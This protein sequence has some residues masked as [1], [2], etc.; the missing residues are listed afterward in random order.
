MI[1]LYLYTALT[2]FSISGYNCLDQSILNELSQ[3]DTEDYL[4]S[5][6]NKDCSK[7]NEGTLTIKGY[8][9][10]FSDFIRSNGKLY[11]LCTGK[12]IQILNV[13]VLNSVF[14]D[15]DIDASGDELQLTVIAPA[16][17]VYGKRNINLNGFVGKAHDPA[18]AKPG[19]KGDK[20]GQPG[21]P[22]GPGGSFL[23]IGNS[24]F[25]GNNLTIS[26]NG[27]NGG[28]GQNGANGID[29]VLRSSLK[30][31]WVLK[32]F[33]SPTLC[34]YERSKI[35]LN[36]N[37]SQ[38]FLVDNN[39]QKSWFECRKVTLRDSHY[40][41]VT[42]TIKQ[43][44]TKD[45]IERG[46]GGNGG[47]GGIGGRPGNV[48]TVELSSFSLISHFTQ[49]GRKGDDG[50]GGAGGNPAG[51][52]DVVTVTQ[53]QLFYHVNTKITD[54]KIKIGYANQPIN[55]LKGINSAGI[56][57]PTQPKAFPKSFKIHY[58]A[59]ALIQFKTYLR[60]SSSDPE[61]TKSLLQFHN[62]IDR[63]VHV[64]RM[65]N[66]P[67]FLAEFDSIENHFHTLNNNVDFT[68]FYVS[69]L[70]R[71]PVYVDHGN[72]IIQDRK[73]LAYG[74]SAILGRLY[75]LQELEESVLVTDVET[76][77]QLTRNKLDEVKYWKN[78]GFMV[79]KMVNIDRLKGEYNNRVNS[80]IEEA[81]SLVQ[82]NIMP[83]IINIE[84]QFH[85]NLDYLIN[86]TQKHIITALEEE[87]QVNMLINEATQK[88]FIK[89]GCNFMIVAGNILLLF[90][91]IYTGIAGISLL[92]V[93]TLGKM[94][95]KDTNVPNITKLPPAVENLNDTL[96]S[97]Q[98]LRK[99]RLSKFLEN[100]LQMANKYPESLN[101][102]SREL[103]QLSKALAQSTS[104]SEIQAVEKEMRIVVK[105]KYD[106][107]N[108]DGHSDFISAVALRQGRLRTKLKVPKFGRGPNR[109]SKKRRKKTDKSQE[110][111]DASTVLETIMNML[112]LGLA[113]LDTFKDLMDDM[114]KLD[115]LNDLL[116]KVKGKIKKLY[117]Y[118]SAVYDVLFPLLDD[119]S[120]AI[121]NLSQN[122]QN[123]SQIALIVAKYDMKQL[124]QCITDFITNFTEEFKA[125]AMF[126]NTLNNVQGTFD[127]LFSVFNQIQE[128]VREINFA[129]QMAD[130]VSEGVTSIA[131]TDT[132][133]VKSINKL[134]TTISSNIVLMYYKPAISAFKQFVFPFAHDYF[135][136]LILPKNLDLISNLTDL[137]ISVDL[138][139]HHLS[140]KLQYYKS[141]LKT[142]HSGGV[143]RTKF[144]SFRLSTK[145]FFIWKNEQH[146][147]MISQ[148]LSGQE[149]VAYADI[150]ES[151]PSKDAVKFSEVGIYLKTKNQ[152]AQ[153]ELNKYL[154][155]L[156]ITMLHYGNSYY[157]YNHTF[158]LIT[159]SSVRISYSFDNENGEPID[160]SDTYDKIKQGTYMLSPYALW[161][162]KI[163]YIHEQLSFDKLK[164]Y[165]NEVD[166]ELV[167]KGSYID[168]T[169]LRGTDLKEDMYYKPLNAYK[170]LENKSL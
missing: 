50:N 28:R 86:E 71:I 61:R 164:V 134:A 89:L 20:H 130:L 74:Y 64:R 48:L 118:L 90:R 32:F 148:L 97:F 70:E 158:Y 132:E 42:Y 108:E 88:L 168:S 162:F 76:Y 166:V 124:L 93:G 30:Y 125:Q 114:E 131:I 75:F 143:H 139:I 136:E 106:E 135:K 91:N 92:I 77:L 58:F 94:V 49:S 110:E 146:R 45:D 10:K 154:E 87:Q 12:K 9:V 44:I 38:V 83:Q 160:R 96:Q 17:K 113:I 126:I 4:N 41:N 14:I 1:T 43:F 129:N 85:D 101:G 24:F 72:P 56:K 121:S 138:Q 157:R 133:Y 79:Q 22:G 116:S 53:T 105:R 29:L 35:F 170:A 31:N 15:M 62:L 47:S 68:P 147:K 6:L 123:L 57:N 95:V 46:T 99:D 103:V 122:L 8:N 67:G 69:L 3:S 140:N 127:V 161:K 7:S 104:F 59:V 155:T 163:S 26:A 141:I 73:V 120:R 112:D 34:E 40:T 165:E 111:Y 84:K 55:G 128:Y 159:S 137:I 51:L 117:Q 82:T 2:C 78:I 19:G 102:L 150:K 100:A 33:N 153:T 151:V 60:E 65:F 37:F 81:Q 11:D 5:E 63:N 16:W 144:N 145:P 119:L 152:T 36:T 98:L 107:L 169:E 149:V 23:G 80:K 109:G 66:T 25:N 167:G 13:F 39:D 115:T 27:G 21:N 54:E 156:Q 52:T 18:T 142:S